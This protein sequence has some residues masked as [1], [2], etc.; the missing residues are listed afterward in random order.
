MTVAAQ[1]ENGS[2]WT[3]KLRQH[4]DSPKLLENSSASGH[5]GLSDCYSHGKRNITASINK[6]LVA[7]LID[8]QNPGTS[9]HPGNCDGLV[10]EFN[11]D[12]KLFVDSWESSIAMDQGRDR[13][14]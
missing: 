11:R 5:L 9:S 4:M 10:A 2:L 14:I 1:G 13:D 3:G 12:L 6:F 8:F 7:L